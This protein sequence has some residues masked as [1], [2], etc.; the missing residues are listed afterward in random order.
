MD[1]EPVMEARTKR[2]L[3]EI[4]SIGGD[5]K[6]LEEKFANLMELLEN[7]K[8]K[9]FLV[10]IRL[11]EIP[12][13]TMMTKYLEFLLNNINTNVSFEIGRL[14]KAGEYLCHLRNLFN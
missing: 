1:I 2:T 3:M 7:F 14:V 9:Q 5:R 8:G 4:S 6:L 10:D 13:R 12:E 11:Y